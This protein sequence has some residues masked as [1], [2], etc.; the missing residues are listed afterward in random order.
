MTFSAAMS[1]PDRLAVDF[2]LECRDGI[3]ML[4]KRSDRIALQTFILL[5]A[6]LK[7]SGANDST[8]STPGATY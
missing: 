1:H 2:H 6:E 7:V 4:V 5:L 3:E 8:I